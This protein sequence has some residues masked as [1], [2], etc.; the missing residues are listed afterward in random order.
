MAAAAIM[1]AIAITL[2]PARPAHLEPAGHGVYA[3]SFDGTTDHVELHETS[4]IMDP[5]WESTKTVSMWIKPAGSIDCFLMD[6]AHCNSIFGDRPR[7][8]GISI[9]DILG[10]DKIW[11]WNRDA[12]GYD[13]VGVEYTLNEWVHVA[14]V[15]SGGVLT[16]YRNG[17]PVGDVPSG[18]TEQPNEGGQATLYLG[19][20]IINESNYWLFNGEIDEVRLW[21]YGR[22]QSQI[23]GD[24]YHSLNGDES[25]LMAY[26]KMSNGAGTTLT[27]DS[28]HSWEGTL[29][30]GGRGLPPD[31]DGPQWATSVIPDE[32]LPT[33]TVTNTPT[34]TPTPTGTLPT[35][36]STPT[37]GGSVPTPTPTAAVDP[38]DFMMYLPLLTHGDQSP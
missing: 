8:W 6:P 37:P 3:L 38:G 7:W 1:V 4:L 10:D 26:Y 14:F 22:S 24:M 35:P 23:L 17:F 5:G 19:G 11:I 27:D 16:A 32:V 21:N 36:T 29:M 30:D 2:L 18:P 15:H 12:N 25:G 31:G 9:G 28:I 20:V 33:P 34:N 13:R